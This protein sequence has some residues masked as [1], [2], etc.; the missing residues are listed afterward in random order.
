MIGHKVSAVLMFLG[1]FI[2]FITHPGYWDWTFAID[3]R[4]LISLGFHTLL[5][6]VLIFYG[7]PL[8]SQ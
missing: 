7:S 2:A 3:I 5:A 1:G 8:V 4:Y 6:T